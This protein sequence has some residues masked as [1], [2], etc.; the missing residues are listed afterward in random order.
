MSSV[1]T[2]A[3]GVL[4]AFTNLFLPQ[5][6]RL[7]GL[8][9][10]FP[11]AKAHEERVGDTF[12]SIPPSMLLCGRLAGLQPYSGAQREKSRN[13]HRLAPQEDL[14]GVVLDACDRAL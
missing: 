10:L 6:K 13:P 7:R 12:P 5:R 4:L 11:Q 8:G 3:L 2:F 9:Q 14:R 1:Q